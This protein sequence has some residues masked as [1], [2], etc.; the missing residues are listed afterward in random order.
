MEFTP[1][2]QAWRSPESKRKVDPLL[3][4]HWLKKSQKFQVYKVYL[5]EHSLFGTQSRRVDITLE[6]ECPLL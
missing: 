3:C 5:L 1:L 6:W 2:T 4:E